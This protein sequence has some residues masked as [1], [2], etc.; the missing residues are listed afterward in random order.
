MIVPDHAPGHE[1]SDGYQAGAYEFGYIQAMIQA[2]TEA[3]VVA[4]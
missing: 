1:D 2:V 3:E 4:G